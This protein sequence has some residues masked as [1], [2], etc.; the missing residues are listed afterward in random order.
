MA[1]VID[2]LIV[3]LGLD[4]KNFTE[5]QKKAGESLIKM[6]KSAEDE[7]KKIQQT[8]NGVRN[9]L[10]AMF[11]AFT[12][13]KG[14]KEFISDMVQAEA[15]TARFASQLDSTVSELSSI[16]GAAVLAGGTAAGAL[17]NVQSLVKEFQ[18]YSLTGQSSIIPFLYALN[19]GITDNQGKMK[20]ITQYYLDL[21]RAVEGMDKA[22]AAALLQGAG[23]AD[24]GTLNL[25]LQGPKAVQAMIKEQQ[26]LG[27]ITKEDAEAG[28]QMQHSL[29][30]LQQ[31][32]TSLG[33]TLLTQVAPVLIKILDGLT[34][35]AVFIRAHKPFLDAFAASIAGIAT[36]LVIFFSPVTALVAGIT[37]AVVALS[38]ALALLFDDWDT[39][40]KGGKSSFGWFY[41]SVAGGLKNLVKDFQDSFKLIND[42][43]HFR[44][45]DAAEDMKRLNERGKE[46]GAG[47]KEFAK[48][49]LSSDGTG[50]DFFWRHW[51]G[52]RM[53]TTALG[54]LISR[55]EGGYNSVNLGQAGGYRSSTRD[56]E[57]MTIAQVMA[58]QKNK[59][60]NAAGKYQIIG[61]T[62]AN[63]VKALKLN[64]NE[65]FSA[66]NQEKIFKEY[67]LSIKNQAIGDYISGK[68]NDITAAVKAASKEWASVTDPDTGKSHYAGVGN[69]KASISVEEMTR[70]LQLAR[71]TSQPIM[72]AQVPGVG[73]VVPSQSG[74]PVSNST[75]SHET[76]IN[77]VIVQTQATD[78]AGIAR[79]IKPALERDAFASQTNN[80]AS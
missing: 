42:A 46:E 71:A 26:R 75:T 12:A 33:R 68:S 66:A 24:Q 30:A 8:F 79:D 14:L 3:E 57:N 77:Q 39:W 70:A 76:K 36:A 53:D 9:Q 41:D 1:T 72:M 37:L 50:K 19:V 52:K 43:I 20:T 40:M 5:G 15:E 31:S 23:I 51:G 6:R 44:W 74:G 69:N 18:N 16:R 61:P 56:L 49:A 34:N 38:G 60:F 62:L 35:L 80:G 73:T 65:K 47:V 21:S 2:A 63:A 67:L 27:V 17:G 58:A 29:L 78:A 10:L 25:L 48:K 28:L 55:G 59:E 32:S 22:R 45:K 64:T 11:A 13:G 7:G 4:P 54:N